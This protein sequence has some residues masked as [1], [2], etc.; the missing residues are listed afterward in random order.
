MTAR[1]LAYWCA[2][3]LA[4]AAPG[5]VYGQA[6]DAFCEGCYHDQQW[7]APVNFDYD[8]LPIER[9]CGYFFNYSKLSWFVDNERT[10]IGAPGAVVLSE[11]IW[12]PI[13]TL[14]PGEFPPQSYVVANG[15][16]DA[17]PGDFGWGDRFEV[18]Y[19]SGQHSYSMG[20]ISD[21]HVS[22]T[23]FFGDD[24]Q[25]TGFGS[26]HV[27]FELQNPDLLLGFRDY[28][29][30]FVVTDFADGD[31]PTPTQ[32]GPGTGGNGVVDDLNGNLAE[33]PVGIFADIDGD[34]DLD[35][36]GI[37]VDYGDLYLFNVTFSNISVRNST[38]TDGI[39][40]MKNYVLDNSHWFTKEQNGQIEVGVGA[41]FLRIRDEFSFSGSSPL[42]RDGDPIFNPN[43]GFFDPVLGNRV[44]TDVDNDIVGPQVY[45]RYTRQTN[46][47]QLGVGGRFM[48]GYNIQNLDQTGVIG[49]GLLP[50]GLN[51][52]AILQ[53]TGFAY[54]RQDNDFSPVAEFRA[55]AVYKFTKALSARLGYTAIFA[56][57]ITRASAVTRWALPDMG[58]NESGQQHI[59][60][61]G[62][63]FGF[64]LVY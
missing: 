58:F 20:I 54:G 46:R 6:E 39:E 2:A 59:F 7:F 25:S 18:G 43:T 29:G 38:R 45:A 28:G 8:C 3:A 61:N 51:Q 24:P 34:G 49:L 41:R 16:Q 27:N 40:L 44:D 15:I 1:K 33:G 50:G 55:D 4:L 37:A 12:P 47:L 5:R 62:A 11:E 21:Q 19:F 35:L 9:E 23:S 36:I 26:I 56:D 17:T 10:E 48:F 31:V 30:V 42:L 53:P 22:R 63:D 60:M 14:T 57:N 64:E 13:L 32:G 52:P